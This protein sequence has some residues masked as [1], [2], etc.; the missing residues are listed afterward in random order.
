MYQ[1]YGDKVRHLLNFRDAMTSPEFF[2]KSKELGKKNVSKCFKDAFVG[3]TP[4]KSV[5]LKGYLL[6][7]GGSRTARV[8]DDT[9]K[10]KDWLAEG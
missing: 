6:F 7:T 2:E 10:A 9:E 3:I 4:L 8:F 5:L 1:L